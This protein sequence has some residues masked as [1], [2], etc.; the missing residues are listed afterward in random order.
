MLGR[1]GFS[2]GGSGLG[3]VLQTTQT[4]RTAA[5]V[6]ACCVAV[7]LHGLAFKACS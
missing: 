6:A 4:L 5:H 3:L 1:N 2:D 7:R